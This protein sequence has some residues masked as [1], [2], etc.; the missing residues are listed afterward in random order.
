MSICFIFLQQ[1]QKMCF[2]PIKTK[3]RKQKFYDMLNKINKCIRWSYLLI[4]SSN[5]PFILKSFPYGG[6]GDVI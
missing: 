5:K 1:Q 4:E 3:N 2:F 6:D